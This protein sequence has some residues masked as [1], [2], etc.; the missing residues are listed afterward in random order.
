MSSKKALLALAASTIISAATVYA[1]GIDMN[2]PHRALGREDD[3]RID[4]QLTKDTVS[5]G[6]PIGVTYQIENLT[7]AVVAVA[8][9]ISAAT[10]D[11]DSR[12]I[13][14]AIGSEVPVDGNLPHLVLIAPGEKKVLRTAA[15][16]A[17]SAAAV[18]GVIGACPRY[19]QVKVTILRDLAPFQELISAQARSR[20]QRLSD[21]LFNHWLESSD[22]IFLNTLPVSWTP[23]STDGAVDASQRNMR[24]GR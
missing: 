10:Y 6:S 21:E 22:T 14:V 1:D 9:K 12:T 18:R 2:D 16:P 8:D 3:V 19:V 11:E 23:G 5:P 17:L 20:A 13:T 7:Q 4:A 24:R 15:M